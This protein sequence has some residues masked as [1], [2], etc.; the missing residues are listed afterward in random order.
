M[1][2]KIKKTTLTKKQAEKDLR[3]KLNMFD[4]L[5]EECTACQT[6]FEHCMPNTI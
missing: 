4:R 1:P 2:K 3:D 6:P 5:P